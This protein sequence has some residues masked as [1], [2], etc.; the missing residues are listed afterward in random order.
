[1]STCQLLFPPQK[2]HEWRRTGVPALLPA[3][4]ATSKYIPRRF[5]YPPTE[6]TL[7]SGAYNDAVKAFPYGGGDN[8]SS[9]MWWDKP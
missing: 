4:D 7:N 1:M 5:G 2:P 9:R 8:T 3:P 6:P